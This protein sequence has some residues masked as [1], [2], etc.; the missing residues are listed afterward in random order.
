[1]IGSDFAVA[2]VW[3]LKLPKRVRPPTPPGFRVARV[4]SPGKVRPMS[5]IAATPVAPPPAVAEQHRSL[6]GQLFAPVD[7]GLIVVFRIAF[8]LCMVIEVY[9]YFSLKWIAGHYI[10]PPRHFTYFAFPW[11]QPLPGNGMYILFGVM[12][13][14]AFCMAIGL[15]YRW[16]AFVFAL[17]FTYTFLIDQTWYLN[18]F[19][20][21]SL[22]SWISVIIPAHHA[23]SVDAWLRPKIRSQTVPT[24]TLWLLRF[25]LAVP[26]FFGGIAKMNS[27]WITGVPMQ[28]M[29]GTGQNYPVLGRFFDQDQVVL[30]FAWG[31]MLFDLLIVPLLLWKP[32]RIPAYLGLVF[33][34]ASNARMFRIGIFPL[35]MVAASMIF[36]PPEWLAPERKPGDPEPSPPA[37]EP[38]TARRRWLLA[39]LGL[40]VAYNCLM[41]L[42]HYLYPGVVSWTE[43]GHR[44]SWH[45]KLRTKT[46]TAVFHAYD[47]NGYELSGFTPPE[48]VL[49]PRQLAVMS[50]RPDMLQQYAYWIAEEL[51][52]KGHEHVH[53]RA[54]V[55][56]T[57][58]ARKPQPLIDPNVDLAAQPRSLRH[59]SWIVPLYEPLP[60]LEQVRQRHE[61]EEQAPAAE[62]KPQPE[63]EE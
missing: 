40:F 49:V 48:K 2:S 56:S 11:I 27:D 4:G 12:G 7:I 6:A 19:Y 53:V 33:F 34:H 17:S 1:M 14:A 39:L 61:E 8:G 30:F 13:V 20:L 32:T 15:L 9:R 55:T 16:A 10:T 50:E 21:I 28:V 44:F 38:I 52:A 24:W 26:Y 57:L 58:N 43:E 18:H 22:L 41:P 25:Q 54:D 3:L 46:A 45:M 29:M 31:G 47:D 63:L 35:V 5:T 37:A 42:R 59:A 51:H 23:W 62:P 60:T 36:F